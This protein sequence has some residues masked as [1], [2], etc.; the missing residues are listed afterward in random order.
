[1]TP[2]TAVQHHTLFWGNSRHGR[3][4]HQL[5]A[6]PTL[7]FCGSGRSPSPEPPREPSGAFV[8]AALA[9]DELIQRLRIRPAHGRV[10][11]HTAP[12]APRP[13]VSLG[14][15]RGATYDSGEWIFPVRHFQPLQAQSPAS[16]GRF[17]D[18]RRPTRRPNHICKPQ[19]EETIAG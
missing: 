1:M 15:V 5:R 17:H 16:L 9:P 2:L 11:H 8:N 13:L 10:S 12:L 14:R 3:Q 6:G 19:S 4:R 18:P 7:L